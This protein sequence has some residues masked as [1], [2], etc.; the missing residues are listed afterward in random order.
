VYFVFSF[1]SV[2]S[3]LYFWIYGSNIYDNLNICRPE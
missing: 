2:L 3:K 1:I